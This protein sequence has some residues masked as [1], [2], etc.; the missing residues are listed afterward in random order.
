MPG[1]KARHFGNIRKLPSGRYQARY[2]SGDGRLRPA[3]YTFG[4]K[5][6]AARW[7]TNMEAEIHRGDWIDPDFV[8]GQVAVPAGGRLKVPAPRGLVS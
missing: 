2:R 3:P 8:N 1:S 4:R 7:L 6:D 5:A